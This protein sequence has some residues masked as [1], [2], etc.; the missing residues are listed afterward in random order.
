ME[1]LAMFVCVGRYQWKDG[2]VQPLYG[3]AAVLS[4]YSAK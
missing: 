4:Y 3:T 2:G 1:R